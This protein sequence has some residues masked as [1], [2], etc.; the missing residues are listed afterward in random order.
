MAVLFLYLK[1][2]EKPQGKLKVYRSSA[3]SGK[4]YTL[5][6]EYIKL[7]LT[8]REVKKNNPTEDYF[9]HILAITFT[10]DAANEMKERVLQ[11]LKEF[12]DLKDGE[13]HDLLNL[14]YSEIKEES[15]ELEITT[16][17]ISERS[18]I[19]LQS[20]LHRFSDFNIQ[21]IDSFTNQIA[22]SFSRELGLPGNYEIYLDTDLKLSESVD[23][24]LTQIDEREQSMLKWLF[25]FVKSRI[26][27]DKS[28]NISYNLK[29]FSTTLTDEKV[30]EL[31]E[32]LENWDLRRFDIAKKQLSKEY[33]LI[34]ESCKKLAQEGLKYLDSQELDYQDLKH[35]SNGAK[36]LF[37][38]NLTDPFSKDLG[39][40]LAKC[41]DNNEWLD[42]KAKPKLDSID[43]T[44]TQI[45]AHAAKLN[46]LISDKRGRFL[47]IKNILSNFYEMALLNK[48]KIILED[49][50]DKDDQ[51]FLSDLNEK[52]R[53]V[54][55]NEPV[56]FIYEKAGVKFKHL[57][58][59]EFQ[60]TSVF[61]W[62]NLIPLISNALSEGNVNLIVGD[63]KQ[64]IY[65]WRGADPD[66]LVNL[67]EPKE[68]LGLQAIR[69]HLM[70]WRDM[71]KIEPLNSNW[72]S[73]P[74]IVAF[75]NDFFEWLRDYNKEFEGLGHYYDD[76]NQKAEKQG[77]SDIKIDIL[78]EKDFLNKDAM[79]ESKSELVIEY[80]NECVKKGYSWRDIA[81]LCRR[82]EDNKRIS[83]ALVNHQVSII[84]DESLLL[85]SSTPVKILINAFSFLNEPGNEEKCADLFISIANYL[86]LE[87]EHWDDVKPHLKVKSTIEFVGFIRDYFNFE[88]DEKQLIDGTVFQ[89]GQAWINALGLLKEPR[90]QVYL[91]YFLDVLFDHSNKSDS[92][93]DQFL[94]YW[95]DKKEKL[96]ISSTRDQNAVRILTIHR[97]KGLQYPVV[98]IPYPE[99]SY[100]IRSGAKLWVEMSGDKSSDLPVAVLNLNKEL[101]LTDFKEE[102]T[103]EKNA[104]FI[105]EVNAMYVAM[106]RAEERL[107]LIGSVPSKKNMSNHIIDYLKFKELEAETKKRADF[108]YDS[109]VL[110]KQKNEKEGGIEKT[111][112]PWDNSNQERA[113]IIRDLRWSV[114]F[115]LSKEQL[116]R[117]EA[118]KAF[119]LLMSY[120]KTEK[121]VKKV[122]QV[123]SDVYADKNDTKNFKTFIQQLVSDLEL[124]PYF[125]EN[126]KIHTEKSIL[127]KNEYL[128]P[129]RFQI[130]DDKIVIMDYK[131]GGQDEKH[132]E[133]IDN[134][135]K[136][137]E[138][139]Y[140]EH[141]ITKYLIYTKPF[142]IVSLS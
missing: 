64:S 107:Y 81:I 138:D 78:T 71:V 125:N 69:D 87:I 74:G 130:K 123:A 2:G 49:L 27:E 124:K 40:Q 68:E 88:I 60:D 28:W 122:M 46:E 63:V 77:E 24:L 65:R 141:Q 11:Y 21:T 12:S 10:N 120:F 119:H 20:I 51:A 116:D 1:M 43:T 84:S 67:P 32:T 9:R 30:Y 18:E 55:L 14:V 92:G 47:L 66:I 57:L 3:G 53:N 80:V 131:T 23:I 137:L 83:K 142:K 97:S 140:P 86:D 134:Y 82:N 6:K 139:I 72:R 36:A 117:I 50:K 38:K 89:L 5:A 62:I 41:L 70:S 113:R 94:E 13:K 75:N 128:R 106:T 105:E 104:Q 29:E 19:I 112:L 39:S 56:P 126:W 42:P 15:P 34:A 114:D 59:D 8:H 7:L 111:I 79:Q 93:L 98:I 54:V 52:I 136:G 100:S 110:D 121:D 31:L 91:D 33:A 37:K 129:D 58:I 44:N 108:N 127:Y 85:E 103:K 109:Y 45:S 132:K 135:Q 17:I 115:T 16:Q 99:L 102:Y 76:V 96:S 133:Q 26:E 118:G 48:I 4:T 35:K 73:K 22:R 90:Q 25:E 61:Q 101:E 95:N